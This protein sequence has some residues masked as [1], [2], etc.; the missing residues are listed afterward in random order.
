M[1]RPETLPLLPK[2]RGQPFP[3]LAL[4]AVALLLQG[5]GGRAASFQGVDGA[6]P[7]AKIYP[8]GSHWAVGHFMGKKSTGDFPYLYEDRQ[9]MPFPLLPDNAKQPASYLQQDESFKALLKRMEEDEDQNTPVLRE[10][11]PF[12]S[13][14]VW[15]TEESSSFKDIVELLLQVLDKKES[16]PS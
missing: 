7:M 1:A 12:S 15:G 5:L 13:K 2:P 9:E 3:L 4:V 8:R 16:T 10:E 11:L 14:N 6:P